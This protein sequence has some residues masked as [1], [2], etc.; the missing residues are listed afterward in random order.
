MEKKYG[1]KF[2]KLKDNIDN[3]FMDW[4][5]FLLKKTKK[6]IVKY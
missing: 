4:I 3:H 5:C 2:E 1:E 6:F